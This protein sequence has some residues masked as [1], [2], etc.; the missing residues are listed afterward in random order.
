MGGCPKTRCWPKAPAVAERGEGRGERQG[1][2]VQGQR[3]CSE[4]QALAS[5]LAQPY[6]IRTVSVC[7]RKVPWA[8]KACSECL[9]RQAAVAGSSMRHA[10]IWVSA[11]GQVMSV[12]EQ[13]RGSF[14]MVFPCAWHT[15]ARPYS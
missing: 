12:S 1:K 4:F 14:S 2:A 13:A 11:G 9:P 8:A 10:Q 15:K 6:T 5:C 7:V 3:R